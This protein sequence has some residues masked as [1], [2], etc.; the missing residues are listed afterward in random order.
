MGKCVTY[1]GVSNMAL[2]GVWTGLVSQLQ[3]HIRTTEERG[4]PRNCLFYPLHSSW[5]G[6]DTI[7][8]K[9]KKKTEI[10]RKIKCW[11]LRT[12]EFRVWEFINY[13]L[14][15]LYVYACVRIKLVCVHMGVHMYT[16]A[17]DQPPVSFLRS[18]PPWFVLETGP[19]DGLQPTE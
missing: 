9:E 5:Q 14:A 18:Q 11:S 7:A 2:P 12:Q 10:A 16:G 19:L 13:I 8:G 17:Q 4:Q 1:R 15:V 3:T 6:E